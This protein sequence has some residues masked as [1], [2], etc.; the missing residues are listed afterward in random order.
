MFGTLFLERKVI[1]DT[2]P[3]ASPE[4]YVVGVGGPGHVLDSDDLDVAGEAEEAV[5]GPGPGEGGEA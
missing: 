4:K 2:L 5:T 1:T 3:R